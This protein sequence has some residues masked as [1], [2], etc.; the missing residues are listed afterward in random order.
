MSSTGV[1][2]GRLIFGTILLIVVIVSLAAYQMTG[3]MSIE[4][5]YN[6]AVGLPTEE[7]E[8]GGTFLGFSVEGN[9][10]LYLIVLGVFCAGC[11]G[12]Y[13]HFRV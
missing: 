1:L 9:P 7:E 5:R 10:A 6:T 13:R 12:A 8:E 11:Y 4:D 2:K 3:N